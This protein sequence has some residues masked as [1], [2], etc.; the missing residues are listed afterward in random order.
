MHPLV[1]EML[2]AFCV[3]CL[4]S[5]PEELGIRVYLAC[6]VFQSQLWTY[7]VCFSCMASASTDLQ[8]FDHCLS[9]SN[10]IPR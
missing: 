10:Q 7:A 6:K 4:E 3:V 9:S 5:E 2:M 8:L 1:L